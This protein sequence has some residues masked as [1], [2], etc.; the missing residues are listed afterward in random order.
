[1]D[2]C[3]QTVIVICADVYPVETYQVVKNAKVEKT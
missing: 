2:I 1:M 3:S